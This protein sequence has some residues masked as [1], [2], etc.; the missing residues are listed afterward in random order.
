M[1]EP[2]GWRCSA[3]ETVCAPNGLVRGPFGGSLKKSD[4]VAEGFQVYEQRNAI[5]GTVDARYFVTSAKFTEM[6]RF[7][8]KDGDF[9]VS[10][11]GTIGRIF[12]IP[13]NAPQ[14]IINQALLKIR[15]DPTAVDPTFFQFYF[16]WDG[17]QSLILDSTQGGAMKNLVGMSTFRKTKVLLPAIGEQQ[18]IAKAMSAIDLLVAALERQIVKKQAIKKGMMQELLTGRCRIDGFGGLWRSVR[19]GEVA[20]M[21]SGG[22]P[23]SSNSRFYGGGIP[24]VS[25][26]DMTRCGKYVRATEKTL[27]AEGLA[28]SAA[29]LYSAKSVLYAMY[30]SLGEC[31]LAVGRMAS[32][33]AILGIVPDQDRLNREFLYYCLLARKEQVRELGQQGTQSNLN[34]GMVRDF[35]LELPSV[36]KQRAI[37][38]ALAD[39]DEELEL[40]DARLRKAREIKQG[41]MQELLTGRTRLVPREVSA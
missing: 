26:S 41:M 34:A 9:I 38:T 11:S 21:S 36:E 2:Y 29:K 27:S 14:G 33:Q 4:F 20:S 31:S 28:N 24:W 5:Q 1:S 8:V 30:A 18:S 16:Q 3:L 32:S 17:F 23:L 39:V 15:V 13:P 37:A 40:L 19:L 35:N 6:S 12:R 22:T 10:C 7:A 25:I